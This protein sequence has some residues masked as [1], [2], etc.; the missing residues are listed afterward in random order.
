MGRLWGIGL[1]CIAVLQPFGA[2]AQQ[3]DY[4]ARQQIKAE[5]A[6]LTDPQATATLR[7]DARSVMA[8]VGLQPV[9]ADVPE[10]AVK[11]FVPGTGAVLELVD[12]RL[13]L[14]QIAIQTGARDHVA[15]VRA[16]GDRDHN[17]ILL[18]GGFVRLADLV[19]LSQGT[20]A[21][22]FVAAT[23]DG[24]VLTRPLAI[25]SD[26]GLTL[27]T[28][29]HLVLDRPSGSFVANLG[30][31]DMSG[32]KISGTA[33]QNVS[34]PAF[35]P[36]VL[37]AGQGSFTA[38]DASFQALG[39]GDAAVFG[40]ISVANTGL[41]AAQLES[42]LTGST[43]YDVGTV[44]LIGTTGA[45]I[46]G[47]WIES[48]GETA[49]LISAA[50]NTVVAANRLT[51]G[52]GPQAIRVT[53]RSAKVSITGNLLSGGARTGIL[54]ERDST[55]ITLSANLVAGNLTTG[56]GVTRASCVVVSGNLVA[57]NGGIGISLTDIDG[58]VV[59]DNA[60]LFNKG[61]G[62]LIRD[63]RETALVRVSGNVFI[64]NRDGLRG[65]TPGKVELSA[66]RLDGQ[67]PRM[68]AGDFSTMTADWLRQRDPAAVIT[69]AAAPA[70]PCRTPGAD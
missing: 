67:I 60:I 1:L 2:Q 14:T 8:G 19:A 69:P 32:G 16:Q 17:V 23:P 28:G 29:D 65:A 38:R 53:D 11:A 63:Q 4:K 62:I 49:V 10:V 45:V 56:I 31:L 42:A 55:D 33:A 36:F 70:S 12:I 20:P 39:F 47:N 25:W 51:E 26:A 27:A 61:S 41:V 46:A 59:A 24:L 30:W 37:T 9:A 35:R 58:A 13:L 40:G 57:E 52:S 54:V 5:I 7:S 3:M 43:L 22:A 15:L 6:G 44:G 34:E 68:F 48:S 64:G 18:R 66:N 21:Q 50:T